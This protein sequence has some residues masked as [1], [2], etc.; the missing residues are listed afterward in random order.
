MPDA[1]VL[2]ILGTIITVLGGL[3]VFGVR[4]IYV[5]RLVPKSVLDQAYKERDYWRT[6]ALSAMNLN[7][8]LM[9]F[10]TTQRKLVETVTDSVVGEGNNQ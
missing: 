6:V 4:L 7:D 3:V 2:G 9:P 8:E 10:A 1:S 5:G